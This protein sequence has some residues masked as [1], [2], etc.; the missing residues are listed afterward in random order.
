M[1]IAPVNIGFSNRPTVEQMPKAREGS[2]KK[3]EGPSAAKIGFSYAL[4][5]FLVHDAVKFTYNAI[6]HNF[7][8]A[9]RSFGQI[10]GTA[11]AMGIAAVTGIG[12]K[13][14]ADKNPDNEALKTTSNI[15]KHVGLNFSA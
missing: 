15:I 13:L 5:G 12:L 9:C 8:E 2:Q 1:N 11:I 10:K 6:K 3:Q 14:L 7:K 4:A